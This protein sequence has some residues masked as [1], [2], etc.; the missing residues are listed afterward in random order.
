MNGISYLNQILYIKYDLDVHRKQK[1]TEKYLLEKWFK[2][3][4]EL[5]PYKTVTN[6]HPMCRFGH[7]I[8]YQSGYY[9]YIWSLIYSYDAFQIFEKKGIYNKKVGL[10]FR[11]LILEKGGT[12][13]GLKMLEDFLERKHNHSY[14]FSKIL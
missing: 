5:F 13:N 2:L 11:K 1:I 4:K 8:G 14:F 7:I 3:S 9:G 6:N 10:K 12:E